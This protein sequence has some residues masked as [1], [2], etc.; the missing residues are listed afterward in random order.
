[1][2]PAVACTVVVVG[3][4]TVRGHPMLLVSEPQAGGGFGGR[5]GEEDEGPVGA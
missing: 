1:M 5:A 3:C 2:E 4:L